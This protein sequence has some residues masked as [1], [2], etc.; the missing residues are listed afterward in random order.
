MSN[1]TK[2]AFLKQK[3]KNFIIFIEK[4]IGK[5]N[6]IYRDFCGYTDNLNSFLQ[7]MIQ[8]SKLVN[9]AISVEHILKYLELKGVVHKLSQEDLSTINRYFSMFVK[10]LEN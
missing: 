6:N 4:K 1:I 7:A 10:V 5:E 3:I 9:G 8:V 2:E